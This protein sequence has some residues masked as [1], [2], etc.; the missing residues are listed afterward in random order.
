[1]YVCKIDSK[2]MLLPKKIPYMWDCGNR[3][4]L[5]LEGVGPDPTC[6]LGHTLIVAG[7]DAGDD[8]E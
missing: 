5:S 8:F 1:M 3:G 4:C 7:G 2:I 6:L